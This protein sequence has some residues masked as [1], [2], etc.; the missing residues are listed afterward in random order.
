[1]IIVTGL[2]PRI[3]NTSHCAKLRCVVCG[4]KEDLFQSG[5][6]FIIYCSNA[7]KQKAYRRRI[8]AKK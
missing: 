3:R 6:R 4:K 5:P 1:M 2:R 8:K 7:C